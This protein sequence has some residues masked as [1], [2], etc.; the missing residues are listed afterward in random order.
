MKQLTALVL[1]ALTIGLFSCKKEDITGK[2]LTILAEVM[3]PFNYEENGIQ[4]GITMELVLKILDELELPN[5]VE[6]SSNWDSIFNR[7]KT[8]KN[9]MAF[10]TGMTTERKEQFKWAGPVTL[11][12]TAF[13]SLKSSE[14]NFMTVDDA[15]RQPAVGV[16]TSY[17]TGEILIN[18]GFTNLVYY[19]TLEELVWN[20]Y[21]GTVDVVFDNLSLIQ[22][23][24]QDQSLDPSKLDNLLIYSSTPAYLAFSKDVSAK[25]VKNW[26]DKLDLLKDAGFLQELYDQYLPGIPAPGRIL[27]FTEENPPQTYRDFDGSITGSSMEMVQSMMDETNLAGPVEMTSWTN[28]YNQILLVPNSMTFSTLRSAD[29]ENLFHW[30]GPV[31]KKKYCFFVHSST[32]YQINTIDDARHMRSVG[33]VTG[34]ASEKELLDLGFNNVVTWATPQEVFQ[35]LMDG[36]IPCA[37]LND[38]SIRILGTE[39]GHPP[40]DYRKGAMLSEGQTY[41]AFSKDTESSY[42]T[43][44]KNTY[45]SLVS[46]GKFSTI[47]KKWYPDIEW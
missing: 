7:L 28:A 40:K 43:A 36:D 25:L 37:V 18:L 23:I 6:V 13:V 8:E 26:Q 29:R 27:M 10:T 34:W 45:N 5:A 19:N 17:Y 21:N 42:I 47:W 2:E 1:A 24:A 14:L 41:L 15:K 9:I 44:W 4:K 20:L 38:I 33:T 16:V 32:N 46:T 31:C 22:I 3:K 30:V 11:W 39:S 12:H 35:K